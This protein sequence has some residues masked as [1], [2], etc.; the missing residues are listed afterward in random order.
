MELLPATQMEKKSVRHLALKNGDAVA[1]EETKEES[2]RLLL[3]GQLRYLSDWDAMIFLC[4][5]LSVLTYCF[6]N[7]KITISAFFYFF[8]VNVTAQNQQFGRY[9]RNGFDS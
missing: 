1:N 9:G 2:R 4:N 6:I 3:Q 7:S 5:P 8:S